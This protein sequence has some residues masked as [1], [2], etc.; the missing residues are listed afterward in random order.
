MSKTRI[1][2]RNKA[3]RFAWEREQALVAE[4][5][6][7]R[8]WTKEQQQDI[9]DPD[10]GKA[11]DDNGRAFE[12]QHMK[13]AAEYPEYQGDPD[14]IQFLTREEHLEAHKGSWQNP[15]NWYYNPDTKEFVDFGENKP[16]PC[17]VL[18]LS[19]L[20]KRPAIEVQESSNDK[21][22][23]GQS[24]AKEPVEQ[25][26]RTSQPEKTASSSESTSPKR[27]AVTPPEVHESYG[28]K[29]LHVVEAVKGFGERHPI[30]AGIVKLSGAAAIAIGTA[31]A[32]NSGKGSGSG[33]RSSSSD[34][35]F[36]TS[37]SDDDFTDSSDMDDY[38]ESPPERDY[39]D[40][41]SSPREHN[42]SG[43]DRQQNGKTVHVNPYKRGGKHDDD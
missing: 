41:R 1:K 6:G 10:K 23:V 25:S 26:S 7:T 19:E 36:S 8:D 9:L 33:S 13:S 21:G 38:D 2:E 31:A 12:G 22:S 27:A 43:Y 17:E 28:E 18:N 30:I 15:T 20:V 5:K 35:Y 34:D 42:V 11:Y 40:E 14:N 24:E 39:P 4:G 3:I 29:V 37:S 16:I 32:A